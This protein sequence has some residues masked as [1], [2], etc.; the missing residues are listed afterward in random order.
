MLLRWAY[1]LLN[2]IYGIIYGAIFFKLLPV[3]RL[4]GNCEAINLGRQPNAQVFF[5]LLAVDVCFIIDRYMK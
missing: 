4:T 3:P 2:K 5:S 1:V